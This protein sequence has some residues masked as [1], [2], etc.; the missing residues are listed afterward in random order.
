MSKGYNRITQDFNP[1]AI[2]ELEPYEAFVD[3][4]VV[5]LPRFM[6]PFGTGKLND[7]TRTS[8]LRFARQL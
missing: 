1:A 8:R 3:G 5:S 2:T 7:V 6:P 4:S